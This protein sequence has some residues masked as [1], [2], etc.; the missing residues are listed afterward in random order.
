MALG[1]PTL[2]DLYSG[3]PRQ[4]KKTVKCV[5]VLV[6]QRQVDREFRKKHDEIVG[7]GRLIHA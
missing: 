2:G 4:A 6:R 1:Y 3:D 5:Y 7:E